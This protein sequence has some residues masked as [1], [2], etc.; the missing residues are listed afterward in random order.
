VVGRGRTDGMQEQISGLMIFFE[1]K[2]DQG[3]YRLGF[4]KENVKR[5]FP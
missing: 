2:K 3:R 1:V 4:D 5:F